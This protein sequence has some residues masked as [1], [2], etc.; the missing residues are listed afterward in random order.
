MQ[1][2]VPSST[3]TGCGC[4]APSRCCCGGGWRRERGYALQVFRYASVR[5]PLA[6]IIACAAQHYRRA[7][8]RR[9]C[10]WSGHSL[11]GLVILRCLERYPMAQPG[12]VVFLGTPAAGS[13]AARRLGAAGAW[14]VACSGRAWPRNCWQQRARALG[15]RAR[16]GHHRR[17]LPAGFW[18][19]AANSSAK[20]MTA[21][22]AVSE[23][24]AGRREGRL[25]AAGDALGH[26]AVG[27]RGARSG[28]FSRIWT[29]RTPESSAGRS[30]SRWL[31]AHLRAL[32][33]VA[34]LLLLYT[35][36]GFLL[37]PH[38]ARNAVIDYVQQGSWPPACP[39][40]AAG[41]SIRSHL[42][43]EIRNLALSRGRWRADCKLRAAAHRASAARP[44]CC[45]GPGPLSEV[46]LEQPVISALVDRDGSLN[47]AKLWR[48]RTAQPAAP[49]RRRARCRP[50]RIGALG[51]HWRQHAFRGPQPPDP[52][53]CHAGADRVRLDRFPHAA[54]LREQAIASV[55]R[56]APA[57]SS[58]GPAN[59]RCNRW[60]P[61]ASSRSRSSKPRPSP[62]TCRMRCPVV[63]TR[64]QP[65]PA[66]QLSLVVSPSSSLTLSCPASRCIRS[67]WRRG[68]A[69][70]ASPW[71]SL[72]EL[73]IG[74]TR[75]A[76]NER[77][78][79]IGRITLQRAAVQVWREADGSLNLQQ[80]AGAQG[81]GGAGRAH[82]RP[83]RSGADGGSQG[84]SGRCALADCARSARTA[85][86]QRRGRRPQRQAG[87]QTAA[88][89]R[90]A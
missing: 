40:G 82:A 45:T 34:A 74:D 9:R 60:A 12:R 7:S 81:R 35:L 67:V 21:R 52:I 86:R 90:S 42:T 13:R 18:P 76:L 27:A 87:V 78:V 17:H 31:R 15:C 59:S 75:V 88:R 80:L 3:C 73:D 24:A 63:L 8:R 4:R 49:S 54:E 56:P 66:G 83:G 14:D 16:A 89:Q 29:F 37:V 62:P 55:P 79:T 30:V 72:P 50:L 10:T 51:V 77:H 46:R 44:R 25:C 68:R 36:A 69:R 28:E 70:P 33:I 84:G 48:R 57:S 64:R 47:L 26:A 85:G 23:T 58:T 1:C 65:R 32:A 38:L 20:T 39:I 53:S 11:G 5:Q 19:I 61:A 43:L 22:V 6:Q 41:P 2:C 71:I